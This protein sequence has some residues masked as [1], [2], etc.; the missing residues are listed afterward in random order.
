MSR[1]CPALL[2]RVALLFSGAASLA[3]AGCQNQLALNCKHVSTDILQV[4]RDQSCRFNYHGGDAAKYVV[5]IVKPP[6][7]GDAAGEG[8]YL[9]Y[10]AKRGFTGEDRMTIKVE[11][12]GIGHVQW[13]THSLKVKVGPNA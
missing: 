12:R 1:Q 4:A 11:R 2:K 3:L 7:F 13:Q 9:K 5:Q 10:T 6:L 8:K